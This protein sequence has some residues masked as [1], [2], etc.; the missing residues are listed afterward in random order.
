LNKGIVTLK[1]RNFLGLVIDQQIL[2]SYIG[3]TNAG[4]IHDIAA[5]HGLVENYGNA[6]PPDGFWAQSN[7]GGDQQAGA[8]TRGSNLMTEMDVLYQ[9]AAAVNPPRVV[10]EKQGQLYVVPTDATADAGFNNGAVWTVQAPDLIFNNNPGTPAAGQGNVTTFGPS[11]SISLKVGHDFQFANLTGEVQN[12][13]VGIH[14]N[15][16][17]PYTELVVYPPGAALNPDLP[18]QRHYVKMTNKTPEDAQALVQSYH[19]V[20]YYREWLIEWKV[21]GPDLLGAD[22]IDNI[23][24]NG[25][26]S[27]MDG[28]FAVASIEYDISFER[29]FTQTLKG[30]WGRSD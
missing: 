13:T 28:P 5:R 20:M 29:G 11:N 15:Y 27:A 26:N 16:H 19:Q 2:K 25:T 7:V 23:E 9:I 8:L 6:G 12:Q 17:G 24:L 10:Y 18:I 21:A 1:G 3:E 22:V 14:T 30:V 4:V